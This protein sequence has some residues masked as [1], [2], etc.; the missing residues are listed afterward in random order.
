MSNPSRPHDGSEEGEQADS[1][2]GVERPTDRPVP[3][4]VTDDETAELVRDVIDVARGALS[5]RQFSRK[6]GTTTTSKTNG[7]GDPNRIGET[8]R[9][10]AE[11]DC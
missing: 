5:D 2:R 1:D 9:S 4:P 11:E 3:E 7:S 10:W 6:Y 8:A